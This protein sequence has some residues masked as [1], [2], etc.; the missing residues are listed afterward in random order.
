MV[1]VHHQLISN[2]IEPQPLDVRENRSN[3]QNQGEIRRISSL[4]RVDK[5]SIRKNGIESLKKWLK[6]SKEVIIIDPYFYNRDRGQTVED[7]IDEL[8]YVFSN[9][10]SIKH[11]HIIYDEKVFDMEVREAFKEV[12]SKYDVLF[13]DAH[14]KEIHDRIWMKDRKLG[15]LVGHSFN[16]IGRK[17][18][19]F[20]VPLPNQDIIDL[21]F[22]LQRRNLVP[23]DFL[24]IED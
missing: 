4:R 14:T 15:R 24:V 3:G 10:F 23:E 5:P 17:K 2:N 19:C 1:Q 7:Y 21:K 11:I 18:I 22:F 6:K 9:F 8:V 12:L 13:T 20:I 16:G